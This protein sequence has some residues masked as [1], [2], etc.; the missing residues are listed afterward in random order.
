MGRHLPARRADEGEHL[1]RERVAQ[2]VLDLAGEVPTSDE[3]P[4]DAPARRARVIAN[5]AARKAAL[6]AGTLALP[7]G[8]LGWLTILPELVA[9]WRIQRQM[10][11]DIAATFGASADLTRTQMLHCLFRHT[12]AQALRD[13][14]VQVGARLL[15]RDLPLRAIERVAAAVGMHVSRQLVARGVARWMPV[16]GAVGV[17]GYAWYDTRQ[18]ARNALALFATP[19]PA[20]SAETTLQTVD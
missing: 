19:E 5:A 4:H 7:P 9:I 10:V 12:A 6:A 2:A 20:E 17:A 18:V 3:H 11:A 16:A 8:P 14:G 1:L 15:A 13:V